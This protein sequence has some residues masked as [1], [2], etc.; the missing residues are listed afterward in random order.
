MEFTKE[1]VPTWAICYLVNGDP[2]GLS[3]ED[4]KQVKQWLDKTGI[5]EVFPEEGDEY[6]T[7]YPAF[8][9]PCA[10]LDCQCAYH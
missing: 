10:V 9:L 2:T 6:F 4:I 7:H 1:R 3:D 5:Y 8:G